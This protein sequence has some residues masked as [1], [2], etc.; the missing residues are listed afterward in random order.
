MET[1]GIVKDNEVL[2]HYGVKGMKWN[3]HLFRKT[4]PDGSLTVF[5]KIGKKKRVQRHNQAMNDTAYDAYQDARNLPNRSA[6]AENKLR[7]IRN[8]GE[9]ERTERQKKAARDQAA[10]QRMQARALRSTLEKDKKKGRT[11][12]SAM[13]A[14]KTQVA[15]GID[16]INRY[17]KTKVAFGYTSSS[18]MSRGRKVN[19][20]WGFYTDKRSKY[21]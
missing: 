18:G 6:R 2:C 4:N 7:R 3:K 10:N 20:S 13:A 9:A 12:R 5:G 1:W 17:S 19:K 14:A 8:K 16:V 15:H 21:E 11:A